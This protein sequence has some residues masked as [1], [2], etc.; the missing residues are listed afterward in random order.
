MSDFSCVVSPAS[1]MG[2]YA[3]NVTVIEGS[4]VTAPKTGGVDAAV[5]AASESDVDAVVLMLGIDEAVE[6]ESHDRSAIDLPQC[7]HD[8]AKA[9]AAAAAKHGKPVVV[10]L[11]N[12]GMVSI[13]QEKADANIGAIV[14]AMYP[15]EFFF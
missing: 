2:S 1:A 11:L 8:L 9:V 4:G 6:A 12:G 10:V 15:G 7:Q 13:A 3:T 5:A 14:E